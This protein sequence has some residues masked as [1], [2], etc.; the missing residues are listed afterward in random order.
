VE[1]VMVEEEPLAEEEDIQDLGKDLEAYMYL[2][3]GS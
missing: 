2:I 3:Y 1:E